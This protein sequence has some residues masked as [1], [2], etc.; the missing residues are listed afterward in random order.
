MSI[1]A[2]WMKR[3]QNIVTCSGAVKGNGVELSMCTDSPKEML[4]EEVE[5]Q[6]NMFVKI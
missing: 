2:E 6:N 4:M 3:T 1:S 5:L